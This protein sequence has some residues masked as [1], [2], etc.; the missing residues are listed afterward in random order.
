MCKSQPTT[1]LLVVQ[2]N[3]PFQAFAEGFEGWVL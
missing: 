3:Q 1:L 2:L